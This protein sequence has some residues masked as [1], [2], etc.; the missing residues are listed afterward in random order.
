MKKAHWPSDPDEEDEVFLATTKA[1]KWTRHKA[2]EVNH[3]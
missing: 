3:V 1:T 2:D